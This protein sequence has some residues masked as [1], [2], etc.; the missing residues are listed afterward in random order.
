MT[1]GIY[2]AGVYTRIAKDFETMM[3]GAEVVNSIANMKVGEA[4]QDV[5]QTSSESILPP[6]SSGNYE[7]DESVRGC[8]FGFSSIIGRYS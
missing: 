4:H 8:R 3:S 2:L 1:T 7:V 6:Q 5:E